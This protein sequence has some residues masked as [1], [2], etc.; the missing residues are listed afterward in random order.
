MVTTEYRCAS[1]FKRI[2]A[3]QY[4][5][6]MPSEPEQFFQQLAIKLRQDIKDHL[7]TWDEFQDYAEGEV[8]FVVSVRANGQVVMQGVSEPDDIK[9]IEGVF[10][11]LEFDRYWVFSPTAAASENAHMTLSAYKDR[12]H[13]W[14]EQ[15]P[16]FPAEHV[17]FSA[18]LANVRDFDHPTFD[19]F[20]AML[21]TREVTQYEIRLDLLAYLCGPDEIALLIMNVMRQH[22]L[23]SAGKSNPKAKAKAEAKSKNKHLH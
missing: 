15:I 9:K 5:C 3:F 4:H 11:H 2:V 21:L 12:M 1:H 20:K 18:A 22:N 8:A 16:M 17:E 13:S 10:L 7:M 23:K 14:L 19:D 6:A